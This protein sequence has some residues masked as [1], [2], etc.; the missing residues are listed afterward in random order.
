MVDGPVKPVAS[1][2]TH[3]SLKR[4]GLCL[5]LTALAALAASVSCT[6]NDCYET[7]VPGNKYV[8]NPPA[9][10]GTDGAGHLTPGSPIDLQTCRQLC[11]ASATACIWGVPASGAELSIRCYEL[12]EECPR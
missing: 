3:E 6:G 5:F 11:G 10:S 9:D 7:S 8:P 2:V 4:A 1:N 12:G